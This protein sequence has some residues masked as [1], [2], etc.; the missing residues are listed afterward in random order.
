MLAAQILGIYR[1][2]LVIS[3]IGIWY[4]PRL[5]YDNVLK[6]CKVIMF[7]LMNSKNKPDGVLK[8]KETNKRLGNDLV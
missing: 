7:S 8:Q 6:T 4:Q 2:L 3:I 1:N 5:C